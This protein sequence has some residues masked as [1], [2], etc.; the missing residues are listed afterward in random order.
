M[1]KTTRKGVCFVRRTKSWL[2]HSSRRS[3][4]HPRGWFL[5][6]FLSFHCVPSLFV[7][8]IVS[9]FRRIWWIAPFACILFVERVRLP[10]TQAGGLR[11]NSQHVGRKGRNATPPDTATDSNQGSTGKQLAF[12]WRGMA[13]RWLLNIH[14]VGTKTQKWPSRYFLSLLAQSTTI[15]PPVLTLA[16]PVALFRFIA[17][18]SSPV[19][20]IE[21]QETCRHW[22][23]IAVHLLQI[24]AKNGSPKFPSGPSHP[25]G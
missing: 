9:S 6:Y 15:P 10:L 2:F 25:I 12:V 11:Q 3:T 18:A 16:E 5:F 13:N 21:A 4:M 24:R 1:V 19:E 22:A 20:H 7:W 17:V 14:G 8:P 23:K